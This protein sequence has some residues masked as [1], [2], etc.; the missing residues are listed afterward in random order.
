MAVGADDR[1]PAAPRG[2]AQI[3]RMAPGRGRGVVDQV[4]GHE[5]ARGSRPG[6]DAPQAVGQLAHAPE[7]VHHDV[8]AP[9]VG[10]LHAVGR[11]H[12]HRAGGG[13][14]R[15]VV[16]AA[17]VEGALIEPPADRH[18]VA[19]DVLDPVEVPAEV[20]DL[21]RHT[22][23]LVLAE[24]EFPPEAVLDLPARDRG[25]HAEA[26]RPDEVLALGVVLAE[27]AGDAG[28]A[29][30]GRV[31]AQHEVQEGAVPL[32]REPVGRV[33]GRLAV[34]GAP[35][36]EGEGEVPA[37]PDQPLGD[38]AA[39]VAD[40]Q[41]GL[42]ARAPRRHLERIAAGGRS[43]ERIDRDDRRGRAEHARSGGVPDVGGRPGI[44]SRDQDDR[45]ACKQSDQ[46]A[47]G[48]G[49]PHPNESGPGPATGPLH[50]PGVPA[51]PHG[52]LCLSNCG[53]G[54][55]RFQEICGR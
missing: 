49:S 42:D 5:L 45:Q 44:P 47:I 7:I 24:G 27:P 29:A 39:A 38:P 50:R 21:R 4:D 2:R 54:R 6:A 53:M 51:G 8:V 23:A 37:L 34:P 35:L 40:G 10:E 41:I 30:H 19:E 13:L 43:G 25:R 15:R 33:E 14:V 26:A 3:D 22:A 31:A 12:V 18:V 46:V 16:D 1:A 52:E 11:L 9:L 28:R 36:D 32:D 17:R 48:H 55:V 20:A